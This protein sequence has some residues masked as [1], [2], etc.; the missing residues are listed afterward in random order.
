MRIKQIKKRIK[1]FS[2]MELDVK[3]KIYIITN[4]EHYRFFNKKVNND[5]RECFYTC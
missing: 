4:R 2:I 1:D 5:E 3:I